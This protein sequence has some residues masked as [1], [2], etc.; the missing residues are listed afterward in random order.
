MTGLGNGLIPPECYTYKDFTPKSSSYTTE[1]GMPTSVLITDRREAISGALPDISVT[2]DSDYYNSNYAIKFR[3]KKQ[4]NYTEYGTTYLDGSLRY[5]YI[6]PSYITMHSYAKNNSSY[7][8]TVGTVLPKN[9]LLIRC[10]QNS[11]LYSAV[12]LE[13][14]IYMP[15]LYADDGRTLEIEFDGTNHVVTSMWDYSLSIT[16]WCLNI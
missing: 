4:A 14:S 6:D 13:G 5:H 9:I 1:W 3:Y 16:L 7:P 2:V 8:L 15:L 10:H 11:G 12:N